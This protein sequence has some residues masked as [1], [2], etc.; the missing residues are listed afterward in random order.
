MRERILSLLLQGKPDKEIMR[1]TGLSYNGVRYH[2]ESLLR[3]H[4]VE[5]RN[6]LVIKLLRK[7]GESVEA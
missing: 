7:S 5:N 1:L 3:E 2:V 4:K 6:A